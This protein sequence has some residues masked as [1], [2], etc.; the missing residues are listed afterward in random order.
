MF[1]KS[2]GKYWRTVYIAGLVAAAFMFLPGCRDTENK[3][4]QPKLNPKVTKENFDTIKQDMS[5][6]DVHDLL[7]E[8]ELVRVDENSMTENGKATGRAIEDRRWRNGDTWIVVTFNF[9]K[10][11]DKKGHG[12]H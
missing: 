3:S 2:L 4:E 7:G 12:L 5:F 10:V 9:G 11:I 1:M 6:K 8:S